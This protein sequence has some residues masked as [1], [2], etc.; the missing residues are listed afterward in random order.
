MAE[1]SSEELEFHYIKSNNFRVVHGDGVW[2]GATPRGYVAMSFY[3]ERFPIPQKLVHDLGSNRA[4]GQEIGRDSK[5]GIIRE[6]EVE[7]ILDLD[8]AKSVVTW[9]QGHIDFLEQQPSRGN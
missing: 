8:M 1:E 9:L 4:V 6:V 3:S 7:V 5:E 2:G